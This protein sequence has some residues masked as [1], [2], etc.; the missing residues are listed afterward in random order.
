M[1]L[2]F[3][4]IEAAAEP[5]EWSSQARR[6][7]YTSKCQTF[8]E[9][10]PEVFLKLTSSD[11]MREIIRRN[12]KD[13]ELYRS[14]HGR[15]QV[16]FLRIAIDKER[17]KT[18]AQVFGHEGRH[19][20]QSY[21]NAGIPK[22]LVALCL[23][24]SPDMVPDDHYKPGW[25]SFIYD[26]SFDDLPSVIYGQYGGMAMKSDFVPVARNWDA[27]GNWRYDGEKG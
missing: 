6:L 27:V 4:I 26:V 13:I 19:R 10:D 22:I 9:V 12:A 15:D 16:P 2:L 24:P 1:A 20:A 14:G 17:G 25:R 5:I 23:D 21:I 8:A 3:D 18:T 7:A 11:N